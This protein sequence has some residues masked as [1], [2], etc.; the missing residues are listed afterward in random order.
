M[1]LNWMVVHAI[2]RELIGK[3]EA[4]D[5]PQLFALNMASTGIPVWS[6]GPASR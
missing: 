4:L 5:S 6:V 3:A 1:Q 2:N